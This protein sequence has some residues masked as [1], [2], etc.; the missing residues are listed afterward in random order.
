MRHFLLFFAI[1]IVESLT[2]QERQRPLFAIEHNGKYGFIDSLGTTVIEPV[3]LS[4]GEFSEGLAPAR[5]NGQYGY[6]NQQGDFSIQPEFDFATVFSS[7]LALVYK[8][9]APFYIDHSGKQPFKTDY[10]LLG[11]FV[12]DRAIVQTVSNKRGMIDVNG[13]LILDTVFQK[14]SIFRN[15]LSI[16]QGLGHHPYADK[17]KGIEQRY[18]LGLV[19]SMGNVVV[20]FGS[21]SEIQAFE[22]G[23]YEVDGLLDEKGEH[24]EGILDAQGQLLFLADFGKNRWIDGGLCCGRVKVNL[25]KERGWKEYPKGYSTKYAYEGY[26]N[27]KGEICISDTTYDEVYDFAYNRAFV[28][29]DYRKFIVIDTSGERLNA[30]MFSEVINEKFINGRAFVRQ[31]GLIGILDTNARFIVEPQFDEIDDSGIFDDYFFFTGE[32][33]DQEYTTYGIARMDGTILVM[34]LMNNYSREGFKNGLLH[35]IVDGKV[36]YMN[37]RGEIVWQNSSEQTSELK[38]LNIDYMNRGYFYANSKEENQE[39]KGNAN[40]DNVPRKNNKS[41]IFP[42][43]QLSVVVAKKEHDVMYEQFNAM[44]VYVANTTSETYTF[45]AQDSRLYMNVQAKDRNGEW[46]DIEYLP[47]SWCGNSYHAISLESGEYWSFLTPVYEGDFKTKL[48]IKLVYHAKD[49]DSDSGK[50]KFAIVY[51]NEY[52]GSINPG[53]FW[54]KEGYRPMGIMDPYND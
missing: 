46:R 47:S 13:K 22:S 36:S 45:S 28:R 16:V 32:F 37:Q 10:A 48:R 23:G 34:P 33:K 49:S 30:E 3:F 21:Y 26:A 38:N 6:I 11:P 17:E 14:I 50:E 4:I 19:D 53:Q 42:T 8:N 39:H 44:P 9:G 43:N 7:G 29:L 31:N 12:N 1:G 15:G 27:A 20:P 2:A 41:K 51:S 5:K 25:Y 40:S 35:C 18:E 24:K 52:S 54:R